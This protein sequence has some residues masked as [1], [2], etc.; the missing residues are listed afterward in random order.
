MLSIIVS[1]MLT[2]ISH[3]HDLLIIIG[4]SNK[5]VVLSISVANLGLMLMAT[6]LLHS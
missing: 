5:T 3:N 4:K 6:Q 1:D 2:F